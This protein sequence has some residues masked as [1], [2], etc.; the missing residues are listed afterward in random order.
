MEKLLWDAEY[1]TGVKQVDDQHKKLVDIMGVFYDA[2]VGDREE[3]LKNKVQ[4]LK[5][6]VDYTVYHFGCEE[7]LFNEINYY[8]KDMH[9]LQHSMFIEQVQEQTKDLFD[10]D[11][12]KSK[13]F[14]SFLTVW[15]L[16]HISKSDKLFCNRYL[17]ALEENAKADSNKFTL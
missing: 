17:I 14:Y 11:I 1:S 15:L 6:L 5:E 9:T 2:I 10:D 13:D 12:E 16:G 8:A 7:K 3:F 4:I